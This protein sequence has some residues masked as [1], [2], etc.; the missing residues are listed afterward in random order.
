MNFYK[1]TTFWLLFAAICALA[2]FIYKKSA[3]SVD[4]KA[5]PAVVRDL[6]LTVTATSIGTIRSDMEIKITAQRPGKLTGLYLEEGDSVEA[7]RK[8]AEI[9]P[10]EAE[11]NL[12]LARASLEKARAFSAQVEAAYKALAV[13]VESGIQSALARLNEVEERYGNLSQLHEKGFISRMELSA[14]ESEYRVAKA[15]HEAALSRRETLEAKQREIKAQAAAVSEAR[16]NLKL[17]RLN[18][19]YSFINAPSRGIISSRPVTHGETVNKGTLVAVLI[20]TDSLYIEAFVDEADVDKVKVGQAVQITMDAYPGEVFEGKVYKISPVVL[21]GRL[22]AR[23]FKV[24]TRL[25]D[26]GI[27]VKPGM[28]ADVEIVVQSV[29]AALVIP[30]QSVVDRE[31]RKYVYVRKGSRAELREIN[32]GLSDWTFTQVVS[33]IE[34]GEDVI[35]TPDVKGLEDGARV[36]V[37]KQ[38]Q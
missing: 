30:S 1:K 8:V 10:V 25:S 14:V 9:D 33:G 23:T 38:F 20:T 2:F 4:V 7:G 15:D 11:I 27:V 28:S 22:E 29:K 32:M 19:G 12:S 36:K 3:V 35:I 24:R 18:Y 26:K 21:G 13:E 16:N 6:A 31:G 34:E 37:Q 17:A 5:E